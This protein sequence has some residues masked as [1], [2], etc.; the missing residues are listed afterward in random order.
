MYIGFLH[1]SSTMRFLR[2]IKCDTQVSENIYRYWDK[3]DIIFLILI[4]K[5]I[6]VWSFLH[7]QLPFLWHLKHHS[8][9]S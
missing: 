9:T 5:N 2:A 8:L 6:F 1:E 4:Y 3:C 7:L